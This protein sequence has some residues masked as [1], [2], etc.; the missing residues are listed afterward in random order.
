M[1]K[2]ILY[3]SPEA[4]VSPVAHA[5]EQRV[6]AIGGLRIGALDN[7]KANADH[8]LAFLIEGLR[9]QASVASVVS[10]RKGAASGPADDKLLDG[11]GR[12]ADLVV[13]AMAD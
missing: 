10:A 9:A 5:V 3:V 6:A 13:S 7:S 11:L 1:A 2:K 12:D 4:P 8:L